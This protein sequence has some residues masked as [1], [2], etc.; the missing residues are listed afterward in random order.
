MEPEVTEGPEISEAERVSRFGCG[1][2]L[3]FFI[4]LVLVIASAPSSTGFA[5]LAFLVPMCVCGYLALK[6]GD[7]FWYKLF[8]GI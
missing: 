3:G 5:V 4:G 6:Y 1:A 8:D 7:E 2:L